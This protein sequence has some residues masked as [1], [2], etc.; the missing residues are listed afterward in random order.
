MDEVFLV[1]LLST[2]STPLFHED[3]NKNMQFRQSLFLIISLLTTT[4]SFSQISQKGMPISLAESFLEKHVADEIP[5]VA[6]PIPD[7]VTFERVKAQ[8][9]NFAFESSGVKTQ[10]S[11]QNDGEWIAMED[12]S[13]IWRLKITAK[14]AE[15]LTLLYDDFWLPKDAKFF[16]YTEN[17][18]QILGAFTYENNKKSGKFSTATTYG[19]SV[20]LEYHE[21]TIFTGQA[22]ISINKVL[23]K[24]PSGRSDGDFGFGASEDCHININCEQGNGYQDYKRGVVRVMLILQEKNGDG[25]FSGFCSGSLVNNTE[26]DQTPYLLTAFHCIVEGFDPVF[27]Q[28]QFTFGYETA[29]CENPNAE[30]ILK[31]VVGAELVAGKQD[32]D[33]LLVKISTAIPSAFSPYFAGWNRAA[34]AIPQNTAMIHHPCGDIKKITVD[35]QNTASI[36]A[37]TLNWEA[38]TSTANSH[39]R[40]DFDEGF[41]QV[42]AS[43]S[44]LFGDDGLLY[45]QL[46]GGTINFNACTITELFYGRLAVSWEGDDASNRLSDWLDPTNSGV[47][48]LEGLDP[49][50]HLANFIGFIQTPIGEGVGGAT[51]LLEGTDSTTAVQTNEDG[52]FITQLPRTSAYRLTFSKNA[53]PLNGVTTFDIV[54]IRRHILGLEPFD[55]NFKLVAADVNLSG[56]VTTFDMIEIQKL[57]LGINNQFTNAPSWGFVSPQGNLFNVLT[58]NDLQPNVNLNIIGLKIGDVNYSADTGQ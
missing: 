3:S 12:G 43:G 52:L 30:P 55:D 37:R 5:E 1:H 22:R 53:D 41:S 32:P 18:R 21:P 58:L 10:I 39:F 31:T 38:Y 27:D 51:V 48:T 17:E 56:S 14:G 28:W 16:L 4:L 57:I 8:H 34:D 13:R 2:T 40:V 20:Y 7:R 49:F 19:E 15:N 44:P 45:G 54:K 33:F 11:L 50:G 29:S 23:Q 9:P 25:I 35:N 42:G 24:L 26:Q 6:I 47:M 46:H 36:S